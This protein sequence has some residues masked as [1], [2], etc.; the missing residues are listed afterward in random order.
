[1]P[2]VQYYSESAHGYHIGMQ[3]AHLEFSKTLRFPQ[4]KIVLKKSTQRNILPI[5]SYLTYDSV[6]PR[7]EDKIPDWA[8]LCAMAGVALT[9]ISF[10]SALFIS[11]DLAPLGATV[12]LI[13]LVVGLNAAERALDGTQNT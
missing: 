13:F 11:S 8:A 12:G 2:N 1:M 7:D 10:A 3:D 4:E 6:M 9:V 5:D